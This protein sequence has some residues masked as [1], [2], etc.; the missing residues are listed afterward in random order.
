M[1]R[2]HQLIREETPGGHYQTLDAFLRS[3]V[4]FCE[5]AAAKL[6]EIVHSAPRGVDALVMFETPVPLKALHAAALSYM[7][8]ARRW[9]E[10][11][12]EVNRDLKGEDAPAYVLWSAALR[13][14]YWTA[15][16]GGFDARGIGPLDFYRE[17]VRVGL[18]PP[19]PG[20][21]DVIHGRLEQE[22]GSPQSIEWTIVG[23]SVRGQPINE[24]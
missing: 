16:E 8:A 14:G 15:R 10:D 6:F 21:A 17:W 20:V 22:D 11:A 3:L 18:G 13:D 24:W 4:E 19:G 1:D 7:R 12:R 23:D 5:A 9:A 2:R